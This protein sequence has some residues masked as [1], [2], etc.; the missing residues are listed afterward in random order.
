MLVLIISHF[1][2]KENIEFH[3]RMKKALTERLWVR[4]KGKAES[5]EIILGVSYRPHS[6]GS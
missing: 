5:G 3:V 6:P 2:V 4:I 1:I